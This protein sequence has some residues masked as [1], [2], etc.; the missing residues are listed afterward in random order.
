VGE[1]EPAPTADLPAEQVFELRWW[2]L[3]ELDSAPETLVPARLAQLVRQ[4]LAGCP[5]AT[6]IDAGV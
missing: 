1:H 5:P 6:P 3:A 4:L 2:T